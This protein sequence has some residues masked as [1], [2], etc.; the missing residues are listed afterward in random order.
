MSDHDIRTLERA[1]RA[2]PT[3]EQKRDALELGWLRAGLGWHGEKMPPAKLCQVGPVTLVAAY[4]ERGIYELMVQPMKAVGA[5]GFTEPLIRM[6]FV[7]VPGG[8][9]PCPRHHNGDD[10]ARIVCQECSATKGK[11]VIAPF[12]IGRFPVTVEQYAGRLAERM[13][14]FKAAAMPDAKLTRGDIQFAALDYS[15]RGDGQLMRHHPVVNV[16]LGDA[17]AFC[18]WA[19]LRLPS[20][21]EW[22]WAALG[23]KEHQALYAGA[24]CAICKAPLQRVE[25]G[26]PKHA[27]VR[28]RCPV[29]GEDES[30][31]LV[32]PRRYP[33][34]NEP[35]SSDRCVWYGMEGRSTQVELPASGSL[36]VGDMVGVGPDG[37]V[38]AYQGNSFAYGVVVS[39]PRVVNGRTL[40]GVRVESQRVGSTAPVVEWL[41]PSKSGEGYV[42]PKAG[43]CVAESLEYP[44]HSTHTPR[45]RLV[46]ARPSGAS[47]CG[48][49]DMAGN[50]W[51]W[52]AQRSHIGGGFR[53]H[54]LV[55]SSGSPVERIGLEGA[56]DVGFRV[57]LSAGDAP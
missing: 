33:W 56:D 1:S 17:K 12:Y 42:K 22:K 55:T 51:E 37:S 34:G 54:V 32:E 5:V 10:E 23:G 21:D 9:V 8:E 31:Y 25:T 4:P 35:P 26:P 50:V 53:E 13:A 41:C 16:S 44:A 3:N 29:H 18:E 24:S 39:G 7:Y 43:L 49:Q 40:V 6:Q 20:S 47:W 28:A 19:G 45:C 57:A 11:K 27:Y 30:V 36:R 48:A 38:H 46:P 15:T 2:D 52:T 14:R